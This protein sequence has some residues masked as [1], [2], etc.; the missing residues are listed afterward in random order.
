MSNTPLTI[1]GKYA[2]V[3][4]F[5]KHK[6]SVSNIFMKY[7]GWFMFA[8]GILYFVGSAGHTDIML[9]LEDVLGKVAGVAII[10]FFP[11]LLVRYLKGNKVMNSA[12]KSNI[13]IKD[14][15]I[16]IHSENSGLLNLPYNSWSRLSIIKDII[17]EKNGQKGVYI[18][19]LVIE[20][21]SKKVHS[22]YISIFQEMDRISEHYGIQSRYA[23]LKEADKYAGD[24]L[25]L[26]FH[27][28]RSVGSPL[29]SQVD[30][31][32]YDFGLH[33]EADVKAYRE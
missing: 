2:S 15:G 18:L 3:K 25:I 27:G 22:I 14:E 16:S 21:S 23:T 9:Q 12:T 30:Q 10:I 19:Q 33:P 4:S 26:F 20:D 31:E 1:L 8:V 32:I 11:P 13:E 6:K 28:L 7:V 24:L 29:A 17:P 5:D